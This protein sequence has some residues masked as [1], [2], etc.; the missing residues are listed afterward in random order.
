VRPRALVPTAALLAAAAALL[1][2]G[3]ALRRGP[4]CG[5]GTP[6]MA[7]YDGSPVHVAIGNVSPAGAVMRFDVLVAPVFPV[8]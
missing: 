1:A 6:G 2:A 5:A 7:P 4:V 8:D 3:V